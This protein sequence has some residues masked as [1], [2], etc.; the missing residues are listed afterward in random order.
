MTKRR[1]VSLAKVAGKSPTWLRTVQIAKPCGPKPVS[2][3][4]GAASPV[5]RI[6]PSTGLPLDQPDPRDNT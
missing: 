4:F 2:G 5:V 6:D 3:T 1:K